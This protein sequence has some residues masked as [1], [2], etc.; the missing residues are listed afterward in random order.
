MSHEIKPEL[1]LPTFGGK[2]IAPAAP[3]LA[4]QRLREEFV[5][6]HTALKQIETELHSKIEAKEKEFSAEIV[7][8]HTKIQEAV[9]VGIHAHARLEVLEAHWF[10]RL[11]AW[12]R[13]LTWL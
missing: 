8:A 9:T 13:G 10:V 7:L 4:E 6:L 1:T 3:T 11:S 12:F 5:S 2:V